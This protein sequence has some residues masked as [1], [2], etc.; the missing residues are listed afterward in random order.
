VSGLIV[1]SGFARAIP[2]LRL[3]GVPVDA[4]GATEAHGPGNLEKMARVAAPTLILHAEE[5][6]IIPFADAELLFAASPDPGKRL[7]AVPRA[8]HND[9]RARAGR[10]Y[11]DAV[12]DLL[13]RVTRGASQ[14]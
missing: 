7:V 2:L 8:G 9:L 13:G 5:D 14:V 1:E 10:A 4:I 12:R 3:V 6:E 11:L